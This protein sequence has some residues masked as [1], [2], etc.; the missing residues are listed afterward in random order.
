ME[1]EFE[2]IRDHEHYKVLCNG[3]FFCT[4][5]TEIEAEKEIELASAN[6]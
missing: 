3:K 1:K 2:I 6:N 4:A 5:D